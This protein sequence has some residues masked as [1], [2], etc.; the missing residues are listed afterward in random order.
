M[1]L[2]HRLE[3]DKLTFGDLYRFVDHARAAGIADDH[4]VTVETHDQFGNLM[5]T[6][7]LV[8]DLGNVDNVSR[9]VLIDRADARAYADAL[10]KVLTHE[11][12][13]SET[14]NHLADDLAEIPLEQRS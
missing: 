13:D 11:E 8:A 1:G 7:T 3:L 6:H 9:P 5:D 10:G 2:I 4:H 14:L 12:I